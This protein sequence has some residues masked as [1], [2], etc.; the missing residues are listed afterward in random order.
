MFI[1]NL[2]LYYSDL[3]KVIIIKKSSNEMEKIQ[4]PEVFNDYQKDYAY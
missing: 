2:L 3:Q 4:L 1:Y